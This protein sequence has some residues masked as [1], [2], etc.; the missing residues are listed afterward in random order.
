MNYQRIYDSIISR[1]KERKLDELVYCER[2]HIIPKCIGGTNDEDNL[3]ELTPE[4]HYVCHQLLVKMYPGNKKLKQAVL[5]MSGK[6]NKA[7]ERGRVK[8][9]KLYGWLKRDIWKD[10]RK[11]LECE[12]CHNTFVVPAHKERKFCSKKCYDL[13]KRIHSFECIYCGSTEPKDPRWPRSRK[14]C[15]KECCR[16]DRERQKQSKMLERKC[17]HCSN[18]FYKLE[19]SISATAPGL[20]CSKSC[21][22]KGKVRY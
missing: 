21:A 13:S 17:L 16:A 12:H 2:H 22:L 5:M 19:Y 11:E 1:A 3:V 20:Y 9:N 14:H 6:G 8:R 4:E 18:I 15:S 7:H 10:H